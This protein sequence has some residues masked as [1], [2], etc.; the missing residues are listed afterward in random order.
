VTAAAGLDL[1]RARKIEGPFVWI[2]GVHRRL[3]VNL[4][5]W[6]GIAAAT[7]ILEAAGLA[8]VKDAGGRG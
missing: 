4:P 8:T 5:S 7:D 6:P 1:P 2:G 3:R